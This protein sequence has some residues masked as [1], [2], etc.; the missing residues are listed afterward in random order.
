M[1]TIH[2]NLSEIS[3]EMLVNYLYPELAERWTPKDMGTF[4][5]N[6]NCDILSYDEQTAEI[7]LARDSFIRFLPQGLL[8]AGNGICKKRTRES[9]SDQDNRKRLLEDMFRPFDAFA[10]RRKLQLERQV[11]ALLNTKL[12]Y[13]LATYFNFNL[14]AETNPYVRDVAMLLPFVHTLR[15]DLLFIRNLLAAMFSCK[16]IMHKGRYSQT[17][18]TRTWLPQITY[19]L[20]ITDLTAEA[21]NQI[22]K[23]IMPLCQFLQ[24]W[25][26]PFEAKSTLT[27]KWHHAQCGT[28][29]LILDYNTELVENNLNK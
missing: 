27:V 3:A 26:L 7:Q 12:E 18:N 8:Y 4:Y 5:R 14:A 20:L 29:G 15:G 13:V 1:N 16:V 9:I 11:S 10:L 19:E 25:F 24:E 2:P 17:D 23:D 28:N 22:L 6:Y 21:Y